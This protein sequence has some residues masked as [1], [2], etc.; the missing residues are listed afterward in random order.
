MNLKNGCG[1]KVMDSMNNIHKTCENYIPQ[2]DGCLLYFQLG[3]FNVSQYTVCYG[4]LI[5][6][7]D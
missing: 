3:C 2:N 7:E 1:V 6:G 5:Y 4:D